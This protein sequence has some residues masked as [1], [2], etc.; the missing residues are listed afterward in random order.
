MAIVDSD[1]DGRP[2]ILESRSG[3]LDGDCITDQYDVDDAVPSNDPSP[4]LKAVCRLEGICAAQRERLV[5]SCASGAAACVYGEVVGF[6]ET[7]TA[8][9]GRDENCDGRADEGFPD[10]DGADGDHVADCVDV[11]LDNDGIEDRVDVCPSVADVAQA[12]DNGDG[13]GDACALRYAFGFTT[14]MADVS[15]GVPFD[16]EVALEEVGLADPVALPAFLGDVTMALDGEGLTGTLTARGGNGARFTG[17][18]IAR[19]GEGLV[20]V[21]SA[22]GLSSGRSNAFA[23]IEDGVNCVDGTN[24]V[25]GVC[26]ARLCAEATCDDGVPNGDETDQDCGGACLPCGDGGGC[27]VPGDCESASCS[28]GECQAARCDDEIVNG[29]EVAVDCGGTS[30]CGPCGEGSN[31]DDGDD[32]TS[33]VCADDGARP[34]AAAMG[35]AN[36]GE[37]GIDCG[38][39]STCGACPDGATCGIAGDCASGVCAVTCQAAGCDDGVANGGES[40]VDCGG[41]ST[42]GLCGTGAGC[43]DA[44]D[45]AS[46]RCVNDKCAA[47]RC[48]DGVRNGGETGRDC[49]GEC[50]A[51][52]CGP[53][54]EGAVATGC[55]DIDACARARC[56]TNAT[57][58]DRPAPALGDASGRTCACKPG[59]EGDADR[60]CTDVD[61]CSNN[62]CG[63]N[64][65]CTDVPGGAA[66]ESGR[67]CACSVGFE[68]DAVTGCTRID[69]CAGNPCGVGSCIETGVNSY[70][71]S[72]GAGRFDNGTTCVTCDAIPDCDAVTCTASNNERCTACAAKFEPRANGGC[73]ETIDCTPNPCGSGTC[74]DTGVNSYDCTCGGGRFDDGTTCVACDVIA[75]CSVVT[76]TSANDETCATCDANFEP[77][78]NG[79]CQEAIDCTPN[80]CGSG[81]CVDTGVNSYDCTCGGGRF[82]DGTTCTTCDAIA[83]CATVTCTSANDETCATCAANFEPNGS[84]GCQDTIDCAPNPCGS[85]STCIDTGINSYECTCGAGRFDNGGTCSTCDGIANCAAVTCTSAND[86]TCATCAANFAPNGSGGCQE[87]ITC[88]PNPCGAGNTCTDTGIN[89]YDCICA[90]GSFDDGTTCDTCDDIANCDAVTCTSSTTET[91]ATCAPNFA[92]NGSGGCQ[93]TI[94]CTPNPCGAGNTCTDTGINSYDCICPAGSFDDGTTCDTCD[95]IANCDAVTCTSTTTETCATCAPNFAPNGSGGCQETITCTPNPCGAGN[96]CTDTGINSYDCICPAGSFD[97]GTTC[98]TC[99]D[100]ANCDAVTCTST[101]TETCATC[102]PN[103]APNGSGGCQETIT[104]NPNPCGA[105]NTCTD[106]GINSYDCICAAGSFDDGTTCDTCDDIANCDAVTCTSS[107]TETCTTC[108]P[109]FE[110]NGSGGCQETITCTPN[111]CGAGNTCTDTGINSYDCICPAGSFDDGTT[112][113]TCDDIANCDAVTCTS[114]TTETCATCAAN[115]EPNGSGGCQETITCNPNPCGAGNTC[116]DTGINTYDCICPAGSFDDGTTCDTCDDIANCDAVTCTSST[117]ETCATCAANFEPNGSGGCQGRSP[118]RLH[119]CGAGNTCTDTGINTYDCICPAGSFDDGTTCDT[120]DDI[121]NCDAVTCTSSTTETCATCAPNFEPNGSGGCQETITCTP[122][123]C[124]AGNTCTDTGIN[125]YDCICPAGSFDDG[126][127]CDTCDDIAN[128]DAVTCTSSTT[129]TCATCAPNF[130]PNG[131]GGCQETITCTPNPCGA[132]NTCTDTGINSYDCTCPAGSFDDGTTCDTCDDI[133]NCD[134]VTCTSSTTETCATCAANFEPNGSGGCQETITCTPNPCGAGNTCTDTGINSYDCICAAGSFDDGTTCDTCDDIANCDAVTCTSST[135]ETCATC[136]ANFE[137]NGS[138]GCQET[139]TCTPNPCGAGNTCTDTG[140]N[141]YDCICAAGSF[142]DGTTCDTCDDIANCDAV[143]C[144]SST[145]ETCATCAA[146]FEPNGSGG[147]QETITCNP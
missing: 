27:V 77:D 133:A 62:A 55:S 10:R 138:G 85:G 112:C 34:R 118:A 81:T 109:N 125:S 9:D 128:C 71:C 38:G 40:G 13:I 136:A 137:P 142:D 87:T 7:E 2:D 58:T 39:S 17:L 18:M 65:T 33:G 103:F 78:G 12:D 21:A 36:G 119:P 86:E 67:T 14:A 97:D 49:G 41:T 111:P 68:G 126:T 70:D 75:D 145:T 6:E 90:A 11:D 134:A 29:G 146:N 51:C 82:D 94:T 60:G 59:Y 99:D 44:A 124:G 22:P 104:C 101:T 8:C 91:C 116:T 123:P 20:L 3:D 15:V 122:N 144:T 16:V 88:T 139:I 93:E 50:S 132:G 61:A 147:C 52:D 37:S 63:A 74:V 53:G 106:T 42:C 56:G 69:A 47:P 89:S 72:C 92:P 5:V 73:Q 96:T 26:V 32:C 1:G 107:T 31:C 120:C 45:C 25:S 80:P 130:E 79:G 115:F 48:D 113:D 108:A 83:N 131:S 54:L 140:I 95:D 102:A 35:V 76:C 141:S 105:G 114:S 19:P 28:A 127:T 121:A 100:I 43:R 30:R 24:C 46:A 98:D 57:C 64:A 84:G 129:E 4:M 135:T 110:P 143:T 66:D 23:A 117:T